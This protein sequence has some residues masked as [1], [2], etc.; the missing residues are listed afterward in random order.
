[1]NAGYQRKCICAPLVGLFLLLVVGKVHAQNCPEG[2][3]LE[4]GQGAYGC[5]PI[6]GGNQPTGHWVSHWGAIATDVPHQT[7]GASL[8]QPNEEMA[9][10][11]ALD[12]CVANGG[13]NCKIEMTYANMC[14]ALVG[15]DKSYN[16]DRAATVDKAVQMGMKTCVDA[17]DKNCRAHYTSCS[18]A[19]W[20]Q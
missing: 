4:G 5:V 9:K 17:G 13:S 16:T 8:N 20:V 14:V 12:N 18:T 3:A 1:M 19:Q 7:G 11:A 15:G 10:Q 6:D 2:M